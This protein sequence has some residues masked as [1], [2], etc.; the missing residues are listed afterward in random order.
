M[1]D[2]HKTKYLDGHNRPD[3]HNYITIV[4][5]NVV[6]G[7]ENNFDTISVDEWHDQGTPYDTN[8]L[9]HYS[10]DYLS[11]NGQITILDSDGNSFAANT[12]L[13]SSMDV[14]QI[15]MTY[16]CST[17]ASQDI[18]F[19]DNRAYTNLLG[20]C[21]GDNEL[22]YWHTRCSDGW[23]E[24]PEGDDENLSN[25]E[26]CGANPPEQDPTPG[27]N[28]RCGMFEVVDSEIPELV[29]IYDY[30]GDRE[31]ADTYAKLG[32]TGEDQF[33]FKQNGLWYFSDVWGSSGAHAVGDSADCPVNVAVWKSFDYD[34]LDWNEMVL[35]LQ[36]F[37]PTTTTTTTPAPTTTTPKTT[38]TAA[39]T[40]T[41]LATIDC[42]DGNNGG[43]SHTCNRETNRCECPECWETGRDQKMCRPDRENSYLNC[44]PS[45]ISIGMSKCAVENGQMYDI[46]LG[47][48]DMPL[49]ET[50]Q[51]YKTTFGF[52]DCGTEL[53]VA[54]DYVSLSN[55][56]ISLGLKYEEL[57]LAVGVELAFQCSY[58][59][60][61]TI[62]MTA[63]VIR[64]EED[65]D[66]IVDPNGQGGYGSG[67][68]QGIDLHFYG[69]GSFTSLFDLNF[70]DGLFETN[71]GNS[72]EIQIGKAVSWQIDMNSPSKR[73]GFTVKDCTV[74]E[75]TSDQ[76]FP[77]ITDQC[78]ND[79]IRATYPT[80]FKSPDQMQFSYT[81]FQF[82]GVAAKS[83]QLILG[84]ELKI[85]DFLDYSTGTDICNTEP[86]C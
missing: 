50:D 46:K 15:C 5:A 48:C 1:L 80:D 71:L 6:E 13:P 10:G 69:E 16:G 67:V 24:C 44:G 40:T 38:T 2:Y 42:N 4:E 55:K 35:L 34:S 30:A 63:N 78:P 14:Y 76:E 12:V 8:S 60:T 68:L 83:S 7:K 36:D 37:E 77:V 39:P 85:C 21:N 3:R 61:A 33:L 9:L 59:M 82:Q 86:E 53:S 56:I 31:G 32:N 52:D 45:D 84:C 43:C 70:Y 62:E 72:A 18:L 26:F 81:A 73:L 17:C 49:D 23:S 19:Y 65:E 54:N 29:G 66:D 57:I 74:A 79:I 47:T 27:P 75:A 22:Y 28:G 41:T 64:D 25:N 58:E 20:K 11:S 51:F